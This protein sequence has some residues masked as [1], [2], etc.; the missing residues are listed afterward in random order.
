MG[1]RSGKGALSGFAPRLSLLV[2]AVCVGCH[3]ARIARGWSHG[4][5]QYYRPCARRY[6]L[7]S[8]RQAHPV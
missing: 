2:R 3:C 8:F 7:S 1:G 4:L 5:A 6:G